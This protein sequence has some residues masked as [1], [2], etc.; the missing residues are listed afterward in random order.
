[1]IPQPPFHVE[2]LAKTA[3]DINVLLVIMIII[4]FH[5]ATFNGKYL[6]HRTFSNVILELPHSIKSM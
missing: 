4:P 6:G 2:I 1:M 5:N 3:T